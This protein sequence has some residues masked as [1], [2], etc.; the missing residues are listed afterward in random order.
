LESTVA[1]EPTLEISETFADDLSDEF[2]DVV[3]AA[4]P[5]DE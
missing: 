5:N 1:D 3:G 2:A 4:V